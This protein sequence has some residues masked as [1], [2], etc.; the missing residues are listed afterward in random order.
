MGPPWRRADGY[1]IGLDMSIPDWLYVKMR[2]AAAEASGW[3]FSDPRIRVLLWTEKND[4]SRH[5]AAEGEPFKGSVVVI[6]LHAK[7]SPAGPHW[8]SY[9]IYA[10]TG[11]SQSRRKRPG[12]IKVTRRRQVDAE[13]VTF[14]DP[15]PPHA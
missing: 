4:G 6:I 7:V 8:D 15:P 1:P 5:R 14:V 3:T 10:L 9:A 11:S 12:A 2:E 13:L